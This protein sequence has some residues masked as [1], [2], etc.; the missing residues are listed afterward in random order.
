MADR[1]R[2]SGEDG[3]LGG[4]AVQLEVEQAV[5]PAVTVPR[6]QRA[7]HVLRLPGL[8]YLSQSLAVGQDHLLAAKGVAVDDVAS[9]FRVLLADPLLSGSLN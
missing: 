5:L 2:L 1:Q 4:A 7:E 8:F 9:L 3:T 6:V